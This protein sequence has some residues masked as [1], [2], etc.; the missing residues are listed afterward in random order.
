MGQDDP[1]AT[2]EELR[3]RHRGCCRLL[4]ALEVLGLG[5]GGVSRED[6]DLARLTGG[7]ERRRYTID[8][9]GEVEHKVVD[10]LVSVEEARHLARELG[11]DVG[12]RKRVDR[13]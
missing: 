7:G 11:A 8:L 12:L 4:S 5:R 9:V 13:Y 10:V 3:P 6:L 1:D 2:P